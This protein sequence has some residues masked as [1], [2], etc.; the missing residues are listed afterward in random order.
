VSTERAPRDD[1][2]AGSRRETREAARAARKADPVASEEPSRA[3]VRLDELA[4]LERE[5][6]GI[7]ALERTETGAIVLE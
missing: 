5:H 3:E 1:P 6:P 4:R 2:R 7:G